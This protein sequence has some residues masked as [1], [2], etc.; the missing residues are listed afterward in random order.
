[1]KVFVIMTNDY[2][3]GVMSD[4]E[5]AEALCAKH[6]ADERARGPRVFWR[7]YDFELDNTESMTAYNES[8]KQS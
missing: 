5:A 2:P 4:E 1:M 8:R 3:A 7:A 6:N